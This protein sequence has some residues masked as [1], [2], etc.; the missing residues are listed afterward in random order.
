MP[1]FHGAG[2]SSGSVVVKPRL[3][4]GEGDVLQGANNQV[5][6][7]YFADWTRIPAE[8]RCCHHTI[9]GDKV[10]E[11]NVTCPCRFVRETVVETV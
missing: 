3:G 4:H 6:E 8:D 2:F 5:L 10:R 7:G 11:E 1:Y 9:L